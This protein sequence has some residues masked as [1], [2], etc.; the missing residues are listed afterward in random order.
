MKF[1]FALLLATTASASAFEGTYETDHQSLKIRKEPGTKYEIKIDIG[2]RGC[3]GGIVAPATVK[4]GKLVS[5]R[6]HTPGDLMQTEA[7]RLTVAKTKKG[8][9]VD[10]DGCRYFHGAACEFSGDYVRK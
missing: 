9:R 4:D 3:A 1:A 6:G 8:V 7:C 2:V 5:T 10:E